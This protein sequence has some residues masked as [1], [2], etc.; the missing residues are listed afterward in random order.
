[1]IICLIDGQI[2]LLIWLHDSSF[3]PPSVVRINFY[4][5]K[6]Y[7]IILLFRKKSNRYQIYFQ[8]NLNLIHDLQCSMWFDAWNS[9][10]LYL[11]PYMYGSLW[12]T[13]NRHLYENQNSQVLRQ[14]NYLFP[15]SGIL[16]CIALFL[17]FRFCQRLCID[18][19]LSIIPL[20]IWLSNSCCRQAM[21]YYCFYLHTCLAS[22]PSPELTIT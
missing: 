17:W 7:Y 5:L 4:Q 10:Q 21:W 19:I 18:S 20:F 14:L 9:P 11:S 16:L 12:S 15:V 13:S 1:M 3:V 8:W 2:S 22:A 6:Y